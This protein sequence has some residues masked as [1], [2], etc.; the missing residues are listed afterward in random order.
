MLDRI[1]DMHCHILPD[2]DDGPRQIEESLALLRAE[3]AQGVRTLILTPHYRGNYFETPRDRVRE[4]FEQLRHALP[5]DLPVELHLGCEFHRQNDMF[6]L[7]QS[8]EAYRMAGSRYVLLEFSSADPFATIRGYTTE[9]LR[10]GYHPIIAH[11]ERYPALDDLRHIRYLIDSGAQIQVNAG[12]ILGREGFR[13]RHYCKRL[14]REQCVHFVG[15]DAH[16]SRHRV[17]LLGKCAAYLERKIGRTETERILCE[18]PRRIIQ[19]QYI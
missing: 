5:E 3:Y 11:A 6:H 17:P 9:L 1:T 16:D 12:S 13:S 10:F 18:N 19:N 2:V 7:L 4:A 8:D 15:S 14:L